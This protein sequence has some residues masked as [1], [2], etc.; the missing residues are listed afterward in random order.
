MDEAPA[1]AHLEVLAEF[2]IHHF[3]EAE[4]KI[5]VPLVLKQE[6]SVGDQGV[7]CHGGVRMQPRKYLL[8]R[9]D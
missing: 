2:W 8:C 1:G 4:A 6:V 3:L 9:E 5:L 7:T